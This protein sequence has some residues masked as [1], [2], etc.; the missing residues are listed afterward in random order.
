[1]KEYPVFVPFGDEHLA[2]VVAVPDEPVD[3]LVLLTTGT[4]AP[5]SHRFQVWARTARRMAERRIA[6]VRMEYLG[7]GD[8]TGRMLQ[9]SLGDQRRDQAVAVARFALEAVG[10]DRLAVAGNCSGSIVALDVAAEMQE[11]RGAVLIL[12][13]LIRPT[14][15]GR[16]VIGSRGGRLSAAVRSN[17]AVYGALRKAISPY[18]RGESGRN[19][20]MPTIAQAIERAVGHARLLFV[21]AERDSDV[22]L[23]RSV[24]VLPSLVEDLPSGRRDQ[25]EVRLV[26]FGPLSGFESIEAQDG[27]IELVADWVEACFR[28]AVGTA[29][30]DRLTLRGSGP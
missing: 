20:P 5:R 29:D 14:G 25:V 27:T 13:R 7:I 1:M 19:V 6:S 24:A 21:Y 8:S 18:L 4:G 11:C 23:Q 12:P 2:A 28:E 9:P 15:L 3:G 16:A 17:R 22:Y 10:T 26:P 30:G